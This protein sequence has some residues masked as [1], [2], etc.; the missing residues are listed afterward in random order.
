[1]ARDNAALLAAKATLRFGYQ[2]VQDP[3]AAAAQ[4]AAALQARGWPGRPTR[5]G[6]LCRIEVGNAANL[7]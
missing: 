6:P 3:C 4:V 5:C 7:K 1:M 2:I